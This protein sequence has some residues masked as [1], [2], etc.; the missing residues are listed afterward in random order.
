MY[1][2]CNDKSMMTSLFL[3]F[4]YIQMNVSRL[5]TFFCK[6]TFPLNSFCCHSPK[7]YHQKPPPQISP[8]NAPVINKKFGKDMTFGGRPNPTPE[9]L[10]VEDGTIYN[11]DL[12]MTY[13][14]THFYDLF[15][16]SF[17]AFH[18]FDSKFFC[19]YSFMTTFN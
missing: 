15:S 14:M 3:S 4:P 2:L 5:P 1:R 17:F 13:L 6:L 7:L 10:I 9:M 12:L 19:N 18:V 16:S 11:Y 8:L